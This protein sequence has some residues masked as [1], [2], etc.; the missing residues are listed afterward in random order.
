MLGAFILWFGW[1]G[2]NAG[3]ALNGIPY[4]NRGSVAALAGANT[5]LA[6]GAGGLTA[7]FANLWILERYT[8]EPYFDLKYAMNGTIS[9]LVAI[10]AGCGVVEPWAAVLIGFIAGLLYIGSSKGILRLRLDDAVDAIPCHLVNGA[11]GVTAV[12]LLASPS[13]LLAVHGQDEHVG[14]CY[15]WGRGSGDGTLLAAQIV[16]ILFIISWTFAIMMPFFI[17]LDWKGWFRSDPLEEIVGLDTSYH[18]GC[19]LGDSDVQP[20]YISA[21]K[22]RK[23]ERRVSRGSTGSSGP[24]MS[25]SPIE[26]ALE[27]MDEEEHNYGDTD[28]AK[29]DDEEDSVDEEVVVNEQAAGQDA[30]V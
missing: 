20:E 6:A 27:I 12:G 3:S 21:Y 2:F 10:T 17:F 24:F 8:G 15:S 25:R 30:S 4:E 11:W 22:Q 7:L 29:S 19:I 14:W 16:S 1:Y 23:E 18:G 9:G 5:G 13:R 26:T 28:P